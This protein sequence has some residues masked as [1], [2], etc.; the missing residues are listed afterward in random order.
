[1]TRVI[2]FDA[3]VLAA[4]GSKRLG[5]N[6]QL[7]EIE[8][9][10]LV[11]R[12]AAAAFAA[13]AGR[14]LVVTGFEAERIGAALA[15]LPVTLVHNPD[16]ERGMGGSLAAGVRAAP[17]AA[18]LMT[19]LADQYAVPLAHLH[20][21]AV[22]AARARATIVATAYAGTVGAPAVFKAAHFPELLALPPA[23][24]AK[25]LCAKHA[26]ELLA[27]PCPAAALDLDTPDD[28]RQIVL[29]GSSL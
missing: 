21:L 28:L 23:A 22:E 2:A 24:G 6:K 19:I 4:G 5:R 25:H 3:L 27:I 16:W 14:V 8:G 17:E 9:V 29:S 12:A 15:E 20:D 7:V 11:R 26:D 1:L 10:P 18:A 13:G